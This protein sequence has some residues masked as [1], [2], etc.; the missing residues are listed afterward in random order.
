MS[1]GRVGALSR[2]VITTTSTTPAPGVDGYALTIGKTS[3]RVERD[4][5]PRVKIGFGRPQTDRVLRFK[6]CPN[7]D[8]I[9]LS[10][11]KRRDPKVTA[12]LCYVSP[13]IELSRS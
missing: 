1:V 10:T 6:Q 8:H 13:F 7:P 11:K 12:P 3:Y 2:T 9:S 5:A 4:S